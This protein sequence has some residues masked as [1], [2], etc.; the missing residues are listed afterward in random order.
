MISGKI[1]RIIIGKLAK[2]EDLYQGII[3]VLKRNNVTSGIVFVLG[4]L[5]RVRVAYYNLE[6]KVY[7]ERAHEGMVELTSGVG[8]IAL[9]KDGELILHLHIVTQDES[10]NTFSGHVVLGN[11][12]GVTVE[13]MILEI[14]TQLYREYDPKVGLQLLK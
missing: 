6:K 2:G 5:D 4:A 11:R 7:E 13:Y 3:N 12:V 10:G 1:G 9:N 8:N 14:D